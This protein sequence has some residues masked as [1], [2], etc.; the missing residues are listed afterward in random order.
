MNELFFLLY[1]EGQGDLVRDDYDII[2][3]ME[4]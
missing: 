1:L 3:L 4:K 2:L